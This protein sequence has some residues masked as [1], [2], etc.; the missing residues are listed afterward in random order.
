MTHEH[1]NDGNSKPPPDNG[2]T[3]ARL[4]RLAGPRPSVPAERAERVKNAVQSKWRAK[5]KAR[6][7]TRWGLAIL[8]AAAALVAVAFSLRPSSPVPPLDIPPQRVARL[9]TVTGTGAQILGPGSTRLSRLEIGG[10]VFEATTVLTG[11]DGRV[12][13]QLSNEISLRL[14]VGT[15]VR[16]MSSSELHLEKGAVYI[17]N[18]AVGDNRSAVS[19]Y[20]PLGVAKDLGTQFEVRLE[21]RSLR[22]RVREGTVVLDRDDQTEAAEAGTEV[23]LEEGGVPRRRSIE[24]YGPGWDWVLQIAPELDI[25]G[26][27]LDDF[28]LW[29]SRETGRQIQFGSEELQESASSIVLHGT[30]DGLSVGDALEAVLPTCGLTH[31]VLEGKIT[32]RELDAERSWR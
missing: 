3:I 2:D 26:R 8:P 30:V 24:V 7:R 4:L 11:A 22:L 1:L 21:D 17:D 23:T 13:L 16:L 14:D 32:I 5:V 10:A 15:R 25:E 19:I 18:A 20:T 9:A 27:F 12:A 31:R 28:L 6:R 29:V